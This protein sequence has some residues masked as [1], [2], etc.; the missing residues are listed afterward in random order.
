[1]ASAS[2]FRAGFS[3]RHLRM[4]KLSSLIQARPPQG[5]GPGTSVWRAVGAHL[6]WDAGRPGLRTACQLLVRSGLV[7]QRVGNRK[8]PGTPG[9]TLMLEVPGAQNSTVMV[10]ERY[11]WSSTCDSFETIARLDLRVSTNYPEPLSLCQIHE[12]KTVPF[13]LSQVQCHPQSHSHCPVGTLR[14]FAKNAP[15]FTLPISSKALP[16]T[17][18]MKPNW[19]K[20]P[21]KLM[22]L[23]PVGAICNAP[24]GGDRDTGCGYSVC[25]GCYKTDLQIKAGGTPAKANTQESLNSRLFKS[26]IFASSESPKRGVTSKGA[27]LGRERS[28]GGSVG[29]AWRAA[30]VPG[31]GRGIGKFV[32]SLPPAPVDATR[33]ALGREGRWRGT[34]ASGSGVA[35]AERRSGAGAR[36][37]PR[38]AGREPGASGGG[39]GKRVCNVG[40]SVPEIPGP[41]VCIGTL[42]SGA[43]KTRLRLHS[44][45]HSP[46]VT[47]NEHISGYCFTKPELIFTLEQGE[48]PWLL[49]KEKGFLS[50]TS[51]EDSQPD[52]ISEKSQEKEG[53]HLWQVLFTNKLLTTEQEISGKPH[54]QDINIFPA[55]MMPCKCDTVGSA[56]Q[57][58]SPLAP[59]CQYSKEKAH[60]HNV[61]DKWLINIKD[62]RT[63]T[64]EKSFTYSKI[65]KT[66]NHKEK[67]IQHQIIQTLGK[68]FEYNESRK[69]FLE[70]A[71]LVTSNSTH[72]KGKSYNG[73]KFGENKYEKSTFI[74]PQNIHQ[75]KSHYEFKDTGNC[76]CR[77][78]HKTDTEGKPFSPKS[79]IREHHRIH[80][81]IKPFEYGKSF[82]HHS[83]LPV[84]Q[85]THATD[86]SSDY[87]TCTETFS[88]QSTFSVHQ[89]AH[90][91]T[92]PYECNECGKSCSMNSRLIWPQKSHTGEKP[93]ECHECGKAF[94]EKSRLRKHQRTHTGEKPYKCDGCE[95]AFSAKSGLRIHQRTHTGE[96][97]FKC[98]ECGKSFNYKSI[99]IVHQRTHTG[100]K[101]FECSECGKSFSHMSGLRNHRRTHTGERPYKCDEC[102]KAFK[103]KSGLRKH[104]RTHTGE[105]PYKCNQCGKAFGQKSQ[106]R[107][108]HRI[109]TGEK[110]YKC[111]HCGEAFS[112]KSNLRVHHRTHTGEKPYKC[113]E[114]GKTFRQKS[115]LRGHQRTHTGEKPYECNECGKAFSEKSVLR[116]HQRT[117][118]GEK[119]YNCNQCGE[120]FSQKSNLRVHQRT[121]TGE[122]PYKCDKC[123][124]TFSQKSSLR[125]HQKAHSGLNKCI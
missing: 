101:P 91:R 75:E 53:K 83:A 110:P 56:Y 65:V 45:L 106:L 3:G 49:E 98:N 85:R 124:K 12:S 116:K 100:E 25:Q 102:G 59:H 74:I 33:W 8:P 104:H 57:G 107:G 10:H 9:S 89:K 93:Y 76:F 7:I 5:G 13:S 70:K 121:H 35:G 90:I 20:D 22:F 23:C 51:P 2:H 92:K 123:G 46:R 30:F 117:H 11:L 28:W 63:N 44:S 17:A 111:N 6:K 32:G 80:S 88:Y 29:P 69:A 36:C 52:G 54:N 67:V 125:E 105:K 81:G 58:L 48:D 4:C 40:G 113:E 38:C 16:F 94:R 109:H 60:E 24:G 62:G 87:N 95:K 119:P 34:P 39:R 99:L 50:R 78:T 112:Q 43:G 122:K 82:N 84:Y 114:C 68:D 15:W 118:T 115:N 14:A 18:V 97:P 66:L 120:A 77:I 64:Q 96:K 72:H 31:S 19:K 21:M 61:C 42:S 47:E 79:H 41:W 71:A 108:H 103:L 86:K 55:R 26:F 73:N 1:M 37:W 27:Q